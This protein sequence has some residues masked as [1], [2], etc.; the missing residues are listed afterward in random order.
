MQLALAGLVVTLGMLAVASSVSATEPDALDWEVVSR[1][2]HDTA[3]S[4]QGLLLGPGGELYESTGRYGRSTLREVDPESGSVARSTDLP[5][6]FYGEGLAL[7]DNRLI[8][9]TWREGVAFVYDRTNLEP[10]AAFA[11]EGDGWGLCFD[12]KR[13]AMSDGSDRITFRDPDSF[14][15]QGHIS[16]TSNGEPQASLNELECVAGRIWAN[17][18]QS[19]RI[20]RI[21]SISGEVDGVLDLAGIIEPHPAASS[22]ADVLNGIAWD[23]TTETFLVTGKRWPELI[24][25]RVLVEDQSGLQ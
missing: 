11:Y 10:L 24:E 18:Y 19:D 5:D 15:V 20:V 3:A 8:Q 2:P 22:S 16:V 25:I 12:G 13:L 4:T 6:A 7:D 1:R 21:D 23:D 14:K 9:L 17:V